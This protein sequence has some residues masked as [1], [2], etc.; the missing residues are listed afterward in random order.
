[1]DDRPLRLRRT[2]EFGAWYF[3][4]DPIT[5]LRV[6]HRL[7]KAA[8]GHFGDSRSLGEGLFELR[9]R[10][11]L[12]VYFTRRR[13]REIDTWVLWGGWKGTQNADIAKARILKAR[14]EGEEGHVV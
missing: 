4:Q 13:V 3:S 1:M 12:R 6:D 11:G 2:P 14:H 5:R 10:N 7:E 9:W 8:A